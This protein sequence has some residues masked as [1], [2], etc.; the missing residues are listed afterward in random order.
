[1][2]WRKSSY[3]SHNGSCVEVAVADL[4]VGVRDSKNI[5]A[6]HLTLVNAGWRHFLVAVTSDQFAPCGGSGR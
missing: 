3:S 6:G 4:S 1:M 5:S 2:Q